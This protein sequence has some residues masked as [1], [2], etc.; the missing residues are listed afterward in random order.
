[1]SEFWLTLLLGLP[2]FLVAVLVLWRWSRSGE[3]EH[4]KEKQ[5]LKRGARG[6]WREFQDYVALAI[7]VAFVILSLLGIFV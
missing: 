6:I 5:A 4:I 3:P 7:A 2:P 1:M